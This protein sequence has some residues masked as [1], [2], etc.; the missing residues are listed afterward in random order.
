MIPVA[1]RAGQARGFQAEDS[2][3]LAEPDLGDQELEAVAV[4][5]GGAGA[6]LILVDDGDGCPR[7]AQVLRPLYEVV[8]AGGA[9]GVFTDLEQG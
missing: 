1:A 9:G 2:A 8:L 7:P 5:R 6:S 4:N 3:G